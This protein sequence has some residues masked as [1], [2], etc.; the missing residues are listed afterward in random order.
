MQ[1]RSQLTF[2][3]KKPTLET[4]KSLKISAQLLHTLPL[5]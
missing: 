2:V 5:G 3:E 1:K 4:H